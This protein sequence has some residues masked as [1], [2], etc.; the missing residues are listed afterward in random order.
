MRKASKK[1]SSALRAHLQFES[2]LTAWER[3]SLSLNSRYAIWKQPGASVE[4]SGDEE[5]PRTTLLG[6]PPHWLLRQ[7]TVGPA[8]TSLPAGVVTGDV[9]DLSASMSAAPRAIAKPVA[10]ESRRP[11]FYCQGR[12]RLIYCVIHV[13]VALFSGVGHGC[14]AMLSPPTR[15]LQSGL[16]ESPRSLEA[17]APLDVGYEPNNSAASRRRVG[18]ASAAPDVSTSR[19]AQT[20][21]RPRPSAYRA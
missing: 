20:S 14:D 12:V 19:E 13:S 16:I 2:S 15:C 18:A 17:L 4:E 8:T 21:P 7:P 3:L 11:L 5:T 9:H 10:A 1:S 6:Q